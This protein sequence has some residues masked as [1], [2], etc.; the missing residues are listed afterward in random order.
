MTFQLAL[1]A[2]LAALAPV[3]TAAQEVAPPPPPALTLEQRTMVHCSATF[4]LVANRQQAGEQEALAFPDVGERGRE[5]F[6]RAMA[7]LMDSAGLDRAAVASLL[8]GEARNLAD[9]AALY[10]AMP[11]CLLALDASGL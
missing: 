3:S 7:A 5:Y 6:V 1:V 9:S 11:A 10:R 4:A 2:A 8:D